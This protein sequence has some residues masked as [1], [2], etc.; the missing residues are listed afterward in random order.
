MR[1]ALAARLRVYAITPDGWAQQADA[2]AQLREAAE[3]GLTCVQF[4]D[5][6]PALTAEERETLA[7]RVVEA[8]R[9][10]GLLV[11]INDDPHLAVTLDADGAHVGSS[12]M[13]VATARAVLGPDRVLGASAGDLHRAHAA[14]A[15]GADYLGVGAIF[16]ASAT[17][18][19]ASPARGPEILAHFR[20]DPLLTSVPLVAIG[21]MTPARARTCIDAGAT[22]VAAIRGMLGAADRADAVRAFERA[23]R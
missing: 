6:S 20:A 22:G 21:G 2:A 8:A 23:T 10:A 19:D 12:D 5:K 17:K 15:A 14:V 18:P 1:G 13:A 9:A 4:R 3:A 16:D 7:R 11:L